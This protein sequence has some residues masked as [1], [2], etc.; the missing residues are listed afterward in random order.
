MNNER[1]GH[2]LLKQ[3]YLQVQELDFCLSVQ[4]NNGRQKLGQLLCHYNFADELSVSKALASQVGWEVFQGDYCADEAMID[5]LGLDF[6]RERM[7]YPLKREEGTAFVLSKTN[8][9]ATTDLITQKLGKEPVLY[10]GLD[11]DLR[12]AL[13]KICSSIK[14][15]HKDEEL[16]DVEDRLADWFN[17]C[18]AKAVL[19]SASDIHIEPSQQVIEI[20][21]RLDGILCFVE[22]LPLKCLS[23]LINI[24][25]HKAEVTISDFGHFHDAKFLYRHLSRQVD[26]RV[27]HIP[28]IHG[29]SLVLRLLDKSRAVLNLEQLGYSPRIW[30]LIKDNLNKPS[31]ISLIVGPTGCGKT[32]TLYGILNH[33]KSIDSK[34]VTI[35]DPVEIQLPLMT[36][37]QISEKRGITFAQSVR[38]FLRHDPDTILIGEIRDE[39]TAKEALRAAMTGHQILGTMH[40]N[41]AVDAILR[42]HDLGIPFGQMADQLTMIVSQR[43][44]RKLCSLCKRQVNVEMA[45]LLKYQGRYL[46]HLNQPFYIAQGCEACRHGFIGQT[47]VAEVLV[48]NEQVSDLIASGSMVALKKFLKDQHHLQMSDDAKRLISEGVISLDEAVRVLG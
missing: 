43:L 39:S 21:F 42:L 1:I 24:I 16:L 25:F 44:V 13:E 18:L 38:A 8:D 32:T 23:R 9:T 26:I 15:V 35:E 3:G 28:S 45:D 2:I 20:R 7:V 33:L 37:V 30:E 14:K 41:R 27:S 47:V 6:I 22:T 40:T 19:M 46:E 10:L 4:R 48:V 29:S 5:R 31:G 17:D 12:R 36:Q 11:K 34:I